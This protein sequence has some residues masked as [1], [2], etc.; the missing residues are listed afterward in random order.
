[1]VIPAVREEPIVKASAPPFH[2]WSRFNSRL[3]SET[4]GYLR[5]DL[6]AFASAVGRSFYEQILPARSVSLAGIR[7]GVRRSPSR[8][9]MTGG[10]FSP[11]VGASDP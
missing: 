4:C 2:S 10:R 9:P 11:T 6:A 1:M 3:K 8:R 7:L 5:G